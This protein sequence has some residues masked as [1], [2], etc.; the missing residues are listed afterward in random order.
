MSVIALSV[1]L[2]LTGCG[3]KKPAASTSAASESLITAE[4]NIPKDENSRAFAERLLKHDAQNFKPTD[5]NTGASFIYNTVSF[6]P[7]NNF[8]A[9]ATMVAQGEEIKC[10]ER[11]TW[12][13]EAADSASTATMM[14]RVNYTNCPGRPAE[15]VLRL[16][17][18]IE[19]GAYEIAFR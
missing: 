12:E 7:N 6:K 2:A 1:L 10:V 3:D 11:G 17:V 8:Q 13:M 14:W 5:N 4:T 9:D 19:K 16:K 15:N 18:T